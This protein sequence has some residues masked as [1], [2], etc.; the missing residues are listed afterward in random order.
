MKKVMLVEDEEFILQGILCIVDWAAIDMEVVELAHNGKEALEKFRQNP[1]DIMV[2]D[3]E[4]PLM[5]GLELIREVRKESARTRC[6]I[7]SGYDEFE[8]A[9]S[10]LKLD[11]DEYILKPI[12]EE[13]LEKALLQAAGRLDDI[14][15][16]KAVN[17]EEK[18]G[19]VQ[20]LQGTGNGREDECK[21]FLQMLP[22]VEPQCKI[23][24]ALMKIDIETIS[25]TEGITPILIQLQ[26]RKEKIR[27]IYL[28]MDVLLLLLYCS[29][30]M[31]VADAEREFGELQNVIEG[32]LG[33]MTFLAI[34]G[35]VF[36]YG[37]LPESYKQLNHLLKY[38]ILTGYGRCVSEQG[39]KKREGESVVIDL[40]FIRKKI[41]EK[42]Q[43]S[44]LQY[45]ENLFLNMLESGSDIDVVYQNA[46]KVVLMLQDIKA[47]Y[48]IHGSKDVR[49]LS[50][51]FERIY[52][53]EDIA[54]MRTVLVLEISAVIMALHTEDTHYTP[55]VK[56]ILSYIQKN[57][58]EDLSLK[59]LSYKYHMNASY[60]GQIFQK[61]VGCSF[62]QYLSNIKNEKAKE[63][64][65]NTN[66]KINDIAKEVG[67]VDTSYFY[68]KFKQCYGVSP[69]SLRE[70][71]KY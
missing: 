5:N 70:M 64:I 26:K 60:L 32:E 57:Y 9:R 16:K 13:L 46:L 28:K 41:L 59:Y 24:P 62:N 61:E 63:M 31:A 68:R 50:E 58:K 3:V 69:A 6:I 36:S 43:D 34:G 12:N 4:M 17:M 27:A 51:I 2:T 35:E 38:R 65:L 44:V 45:L 40:P 21:S 48:Q 20:F 25:E 14:D 22:E 55:V 54:G 71:K 37:N 42:D 66:M 15:R 52:Q 7:L 11:V 47:E 23:Y 18:I 1:V 30:D 67:Y 10:A 33:I 29:K 49:S 8:Y 56:E 39:L 19:W 53:A